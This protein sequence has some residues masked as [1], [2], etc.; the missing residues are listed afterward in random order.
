MAIHDNF[1]AKYD[2]LL[3]YLQVETQEVTPEYARVRMPLS[4]D[5]LNG[6]GAAHGGAIATLID[7]AFG[8]AA[9]DNRDR[10][11]VTLST[12]IEYL[13]PGLKG[14]LTGEARLIRAG[15]R[16]L[17]YDVQI[18]DAEGK[19]VARALVSGYVTDREFPA[20]V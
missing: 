3:Q 11:V 1:V 12:S 5:H 20:V 14:P 9:N 10:S 6:F 2:R 15:K 7:A 16:I 19:I 4:K 18:I 17:N 8:I 13:R